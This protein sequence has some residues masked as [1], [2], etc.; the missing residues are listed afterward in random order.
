MKRGYSNNKVIKSNMDKTI[1]FYTAIN[2][3]IIYDKDYRE[4]FDNAVQF[5]YGEPLEEYSEKSINAIMVNDIR[6]NCSN[7]DQVLKRIYKIRRSDNDYAQYKNSVLE[8]I[9]NTYPG[10]RDECLKQKRKFDMVVI[11]K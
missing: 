5:G 3:V 4:I 7:Y 2:S 10:L 1:D 9:A 8:K 11:C 6:H